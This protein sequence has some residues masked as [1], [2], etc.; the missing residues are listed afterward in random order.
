MIRFFLS[1]LGASLRSWFFVYVLASVVLI[2]SGIGIV[3]QTT[4]VSVFFERFFL[5]L[6][7]FDFLNLM[8]YAKWLGIVLVGLPLLGFVGSRGYHAVRKPAGFWNEIVFLF[9]LSVVLNLLVT[10]FAF[11]VF[12]PEGF[13]ASIGLVFVVLV[14]F[15]VFSFLALMLFAIANTGSW[16]NSVSSGFSTNFRVIK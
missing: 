5:P 6:V 14:V 4:A 16:V 1:Y 3:L 8:D 13:L 12:H 7:S 9:G 2:A 15:F 10:V 11:V